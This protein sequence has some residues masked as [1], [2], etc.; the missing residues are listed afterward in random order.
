MDENL[1]DMQAIINEMKRLQEELANMKKNNTNVTTVYNNM[2]EDIVVMSLNPGILNLSTEP[3][4]RGVI[5]TFREFGEEIV[6]PTSDLKLIVRNNKSFVNG[7]KLYICDDN[8]IKS[9]RLERVYE[10]ILDRAQIESIVNNDK[11]LFD[12]V[13]KKMTDVQKN[14]LADLLIKKI[15]DG[16]K[17][18]MNIVS[19]IE[20]S[21]SINITEKANQAKE[22]LKETKQSE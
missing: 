13:F 19:R 22:L 14:T 8:F 4:G 7:G 10:S 5:Y 9:N 3:Y 12:K 18:D 15:V 11:T 17:V 1:N 16:K 2:D 6:I 20:S 21:T